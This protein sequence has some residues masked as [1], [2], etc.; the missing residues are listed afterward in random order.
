[1]VRRIWEPER[2]MQSNYGVTTIVEQIIAKPVGN[3]M[4]N[5]ASRSQGIKESTKALAAEASIDN[6][7][8][9]CRS[10][11]SDKSKVLAYC[12]P[13]LATIRSLLNQKLQITPQVCRCLIKVPLFLRS[14]LKLKHIETRLLTH[15]CQITWVVLETPSPPM[16]LVGR[17]FTL[18]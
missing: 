16:T 10:L 9:G 5:R 1:M 11:T 14:S 7:Q 15:V 18:L 12:K 17:I 2:K 13:F 8:T 3:S 4:A 6:N